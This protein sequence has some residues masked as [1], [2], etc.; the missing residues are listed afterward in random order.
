MTWPAF[1]MLSALLLPGGGAC[2]VECFEFYLPFLFF[3]FSFSSI[4]VLCV[5]SSEARSK[6]C[7]LFS[8]HYVVGWAPDGP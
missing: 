7:I 5:Y 6:S 1:V 3:F 8:K 2:A 4:Y